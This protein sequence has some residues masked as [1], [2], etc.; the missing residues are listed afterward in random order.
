MR[1]HTESTA[2]DFF[3]QREP[4]NGVRLPHPLSTRQTLLGGR[5]S[6]ITVHPLDQ[7]C[8]RFRIMQLAKVILREE[9]MHDKIVQYTNPGMPSRQ[10]EDLAVKWQVVS[11]IVDHYIILT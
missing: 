8:I 2:D 6:V 1:H 4:G 10:Q 9:V 3:E 5:P 7:K 11:K